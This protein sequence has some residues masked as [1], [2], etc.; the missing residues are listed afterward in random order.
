MFAL[1]IINL[2]HSISNYGDTG[3]MPICSHCWEVIHEQAGQ[4]HHS[5]IYHCC[6][7]HILLHL[8]DWS[9][10]MTACPEQKY[11]SRVRLWDCHHPSQ[12]YSPV[13]IPL[14]HSMNSTT[15]MWR[16]GG[17]YGMEIV[18][19]NHHLILVFGILWWI[20]CVMVCYVRICIRR[21]TSATNGTPWEA[22]K[23]MY[24]SWWGETIFCTMI[25]HARWLN[26]EKVYVP[27]FGSVVLLWQWCLS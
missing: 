12:D 24:C 9:G 26:T 6:L 13:A 3:I 2:H 4:L 20:C 19:F 14:L 8:L 25:R 15:M 5:S 23:W 10:F 17:E 27:E 11:A 1:Q 21:D 22:H 7:L 16:W 18:G